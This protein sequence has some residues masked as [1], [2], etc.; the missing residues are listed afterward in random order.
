MK[1]SNIK[2]DVILCSSWGRTQ[3]NVDFYIV[4][5]R[6][7][8]VVTLQKLGKDEVFD[9]ETKKDSGTC[10]PKIDKFVDEP[11]TKKLNKYG[12]LAISG[13][14]YCELWNGDPLQWCRGDCE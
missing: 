12:S 1:K 14:S 7:G 2:K 6:K 11:F 10:T 13:V 9:D 8:D 3:T 5:D 4:V